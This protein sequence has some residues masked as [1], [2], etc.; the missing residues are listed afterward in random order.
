M[1]SREI[2]GIA[3]EFQISLRNR[4]VDGR[5]GLKIREGK[6]GKYKKHLLSEDLEFANNLYDSLNPVLKKLV[7]INEL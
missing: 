6:T 1:Q 3:N 5:E 4:K 7:R 2:E